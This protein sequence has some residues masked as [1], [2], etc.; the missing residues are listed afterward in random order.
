MPP[1]IISLP[2][3]IDEFLFP[4]PIVEEEQANWPAAATKSWMAANPIVCRIIGPEMKPGSFQH[5]RSRYVNKRDLPKIIEN[6]RLPG[7]HEPTATLVHLIRHVRES[8]ENV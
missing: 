7:A 2:L 4:H 1:S 3:Y 6:V 5:A 8:V